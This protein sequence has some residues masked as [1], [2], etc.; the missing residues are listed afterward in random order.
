MLGPI[1]NK[2]KLCI[3]FPRK[4]T[5]LAKNEDFVGLINVVLE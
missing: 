1:S 2:I 5:E 4:N 3:E